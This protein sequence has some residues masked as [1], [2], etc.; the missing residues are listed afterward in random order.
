VWWG[1]N[2]LW[3]EHLLAVIRRIFVGLEEGDGKM[4]DKCGS[5]VGISR[6]LK[7]LFQERE[8]GCLQRREHAQPLFFLP[9]EDVK[10][11][12]ELFL[13]DKETLTEP[14]HRSRTQEILRKNPEDEKETIG[15]VGDDEVREDG[16]CMAAGTDKAQDAEAVADRVSMNKVNK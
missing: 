3:I 1:G 16:M 13:R 14:L 4:A 15:G 6:Y 12:V 7:K 9:P 2:I 8:A 11:A 5:K 10:P